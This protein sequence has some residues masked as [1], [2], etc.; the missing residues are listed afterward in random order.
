VAAHV[1]A[2]ADPDTGLA[3]ESALPQGRPWQ[4][5]D[6]GWGE[7]SGRTDLFVSIDTIGRT[8]DRRDDFAEVYGDWDEVSGRLT[9]PDQDGADGA[10]GT[11]SRSVNVAAAPAAARPGEVAAALRQAE[12]DPA[13]LTDDQAIAL[14]SADGDDLEALAAIADGL[15][16]EVNGDD[17]TFV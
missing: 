13:A 4:E 16:R 5:P 15:R 7:S 2:L 9:S 11:R 1:A 6:G 14:L 8:H 10:G 12:R 17:V 3:D